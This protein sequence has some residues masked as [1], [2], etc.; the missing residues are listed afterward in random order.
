MAWGNSRGVSIDRA[1]TD[2]FGALE[3]GTA[4]A[5]YD[6]SLTKKIEAEPVKKHFVEMTKAAISGREAGT[7]G[8]V[9]IP[10]YLD[11]SLVDVTA[12]ATP[13]RT[14][15]RR[16]ANRGKSADYD[17]LIARGAVDWKVEDASLTETEDTYETKNKVI[18][19]LYAVGRVTGP[20]YAAS[21]ERVAEWGSSDW[22]NLEVQNKTRSLIEEEENAL[23][24]GNWSSTDADA[25]LGILKEIYDN[26]NKTD[27]TGAAEITLADLDE[28]IRVCRTANDSTTLGGADP[29]V[30]ITDYATE[31]KIKGLFY[32][33]YRFAAPTTTLGWGA[34]TAVYNG[35]PVVGSR[36]MTAA[37]TNRDLALLNTDYIETRVLQDITYEE[38]AKTNDS[39]KFFLKEYLTFVVKAPE[40]MNLF[41]DLT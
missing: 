32:D 33:A 35:I 34:T 16:V 11:P 3:H 8:K 13:L 4:Y 24:N 2:A 37:T 17:R 27:K 15:V 41:Y 7:A 20:L 1:Y 29:N 40:Y 12:K 5:G 14:M 26:G 21:K 30:F 31:N 10:I 22:M 9:G 23:I 39:D 19:Y 6:Y 28:M 38:L 18:K 36:V 25:P